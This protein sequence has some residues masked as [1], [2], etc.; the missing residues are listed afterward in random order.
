M[1]TGR[2]LI[3]SAVVAGL[4]ALAGSVAWACTAA[5]GPFVAQPTPDKVAVQQATTV[6]G[7]GWAANSPIEIGWSKSSTKDFHS[8]AVATTDGS[9]AVS[10]TMQVPDLP[11]GDYYVQAKQGDV[12]QGGATFEILNPQGTS[13][14]AAAQ[15]QAL[16]GQQWSDVRAT[17]GHAPGLADLPRSAHSSSTSLL[18]FLAVGGG[19]TVLAAGLAAAEVRRRRVHA[20]VGVR[21]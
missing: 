21:R 10:A 12:I 3:G 16:S 19:A 13:S 5:S 15:A 17:G 14:A 6:T 1:R 4:V 20:K 18:P 9:G 11:P 7:G 8:L 2:G